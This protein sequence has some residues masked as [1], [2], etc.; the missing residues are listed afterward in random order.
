LQPGGPKFFVPFVALAKA[1]LTNEIRSPMPLGSRVGT[2]TVREIEKMASIKIYER[3]IICLRNRASGSRRNQIGMI[4][5]GLL[6]LDNKDLENFHR[7]TRPGASILGA[8]KILPPMAV[9]RHP[10]A[11]VR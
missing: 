4:I 5:V 6:K 3:R 11:F 10:L 1:G 2:M 9:H 8:D 7:R